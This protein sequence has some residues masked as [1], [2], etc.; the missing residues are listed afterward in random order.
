MPW[1]RVDDSFYDHPKLDRLGSL[2]LSAIGLY[3]LAVSWSNRYLTDGHLPSDRVRRLG[4]TLRQAEALVAADLWHPARVQCQSEDC[5][6]PEDEGYR[7]H[8]FWTF[9]KSRRQVT[10]ERADKSEAGRQGGLN[11][12]VSRRE[13]GTKHSASTVLDVRL[14]SR[15]VHSVPDHSRPAPSSPRETTDLKII[16]TDEDKEKRLRRILTDGEA[17]SWKREA[18]QGELQRMGAAS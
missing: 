15:P 9:N 14:N 6:P 18:A 10:K 17:P 11:S 13:A 1:G 12:G 3:W 7:I 16:E 5:P 2:R 8:D 4:A